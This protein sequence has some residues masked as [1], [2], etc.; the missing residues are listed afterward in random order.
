MTKRDLFC[1]DNLGLMRS[2]DSASIDLIYLDP[3]FNSSADYN[4]THR[5]IDGR[6]ADAQIQAFEDTWHWGSAAAQ[7]LNGLCD[8]V[9]LHGFLEALTH[10][11]GENDLTAYLVFMSERLLEMHRLLRDTGSIYLHCDDTAAAYLKVVM[12]LVFGRQQYRNTITWER[13]DPRNGATKQFGRCTDTILF[14]AKD[15]QWTFAPQYT[16]LKQGYVES[17]YKF[18]DGDGR[19]YRKDGLHAPDDP[20]G[21][22]PKYCFKAK[23]GISYAP[24]AKGWRCTQ[25]EMQRLDDAG[26]LAYPEKASGRLSRKRYLDE[27]KGTPVTSLWTDIGALDRPDYSTQKPQALLERIISASSNPGDVV[28]DPFCGGGTTIKAAESLGRQWV[29]IDLT[30][31]AIGEVKKALRSQFGLDIQEQGMPEAPDDALALAV[32]DPFQFQLWLATKL[33]ASPV[34]SPEG[35]TYMFDQYVDLVDGKVKQGRVAFLGCIEHEPTP[36]CL[37]N[38]RI[39]MRRASADI[40]YLITH[41]PPGAEVEAAAQKAGEI[42]TRNGKRNLPKVNLVLVK[43]VLKKGR[44]ICPLQR[45]QESKPAPATHRVLELV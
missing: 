6:A 41:V 28:F 2:M 11:L 18:D 35:F 34:Q 22:R 26:L 13:S 10:A 20:K 15:K 16:A 45:R 24:P 1:G 43:D 12:D 31:L 4:K 36:S 39:A 38:L 17:F 29:G 23:N 44:D 14:Y 9:E 19:L 32:S 40:G 27:S 8:N 3:P 37:R 42:K 25:Q 21:T 5:H 30:M 7:A 33:E